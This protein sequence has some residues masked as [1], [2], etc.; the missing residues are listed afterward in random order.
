MFII[1][2]GCKTLDCK[3]KSNWKTDIKHW[4]KKAGI[5]NSLEIT[6]KLNSMAVRY[7]KVKKWSNNF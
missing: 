1:S 3:K 2:V 5:V 7:I 6:L 4:F